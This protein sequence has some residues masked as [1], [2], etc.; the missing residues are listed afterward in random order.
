MELIDRFA[1]DCMVLKIGS[2]ELVEIAERK[3]M[4]LPYDRKI[5]GQVLREWCEGNLVP[6][7]VVLGCTHFPHLRKEIQ[8]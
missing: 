6:D 4:G 8:A 5:I 2:S 3:M 7:T 1:S